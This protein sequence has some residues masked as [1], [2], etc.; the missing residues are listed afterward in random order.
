MDL[1]VVYLLVSCLVLWYSSSGGLALSRALGQLKEH[2]SMQHCQ[3]S[4][5]EFKIAK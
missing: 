5:G 4:N 3:R 2:L 1:R